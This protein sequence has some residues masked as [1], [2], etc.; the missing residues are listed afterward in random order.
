MSD[1]KTNT[2]SSSTTSVPSMPGQAFESVRLPPITLDGK[3][4]DKQFDINIAGGCEISN[5]GTQGRVLGSLSCL[6]PSTGNIPIVESVNSPRKKVSPF[7]DSHKAYKTDKGIIFLNLPFNFVE[8]VKKYPYK[9][10]VREG[11]SEDKYAAALHRYIPGSID[12]EETRSVNLTPGIVA[13]SNGKVPLSLGCIRLPADSY[14]IIE[15]SYVPPSE[16]V[17][18]GNPN[19][20]GDRID[21]VLRTAEFYERDQTVIANF[22]PHLRDHV[23]NMEVN[24]VVK[25][26]KLDLPQALK[27]LSKQAEVVGATLV[28]KEDLNGGSLPQGKVW[29][30]S[31]AKIQEAIQYSHA[32]HPD[33]KNARLTDIRNAINETKNE[34]RDTLANKYEQ[35]ERKVL[36]GIDREKLQSKIDAIATKSIVPFSIFANIGEVINP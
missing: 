7:E 34:K 9:I 15:N 14:K 18:L 26:E 23:Y 17:H 28:I 11:E 31:K 22:H 4:V 19:R 2:N 33:A 13:Y 12:T 25:I 29:L 5:I 36:E 16:A 30:V 20:K 27:I 8:E 1:P 21:V 10:P 35:K 32:I 3:N 24:R 6:G